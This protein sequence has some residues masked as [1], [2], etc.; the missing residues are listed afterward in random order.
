METDNN[1]LINELLAVTEA[2]TEKARKLRQLPESK[3]NFKEDPE[4]WSIL[5]CI[6]H[7]NRYGDYYL[8]EIEK[9]VYC[10]RLCILSFTRFISASL[11]RALTV[12]LLI[13]SM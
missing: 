4:K 7:L 12:V 2:A 5:E 13:A 1:T 9:A 10:F 3:L 11:D 6:E 8:P